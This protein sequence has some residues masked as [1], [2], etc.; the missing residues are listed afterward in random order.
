M[1]LASLGFAS[2][3][4]LAAPLLPQ[5]ERELRGVHRVGLTGRTTDPKEGQQGLRRQLWQ[6]HE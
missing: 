1:G 3:F 2:V 5:A 6:Q 4:G